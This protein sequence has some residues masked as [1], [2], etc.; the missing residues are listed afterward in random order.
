MCW[1]RHVSDWSTS[2]DIPQQFGTESDWKGIALDQLSFCGLKTDGSV[3]C[4]GKMGTGNNALY[5]NKIPE[6]VVFE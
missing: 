6:R 3:W 4:W 5:D 1:G 2:F